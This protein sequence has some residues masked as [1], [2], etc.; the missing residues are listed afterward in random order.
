MAVAP[1]FQVFPWGTQEFPV[2]IVMARP[3]ILGGVT[4]ESPLT[5]L[6]LKPTFR[7]GVGSEVNLFGLYPSDI[8]LG[9]EV[10]STAEATWKFGIKSLKF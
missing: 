8:S 2:G 7:V 6:D 3:Y 10:D 9:V 5:E 1:Q 4:V